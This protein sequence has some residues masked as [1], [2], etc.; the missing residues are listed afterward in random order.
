MEIDV[1]D[2]TQA[3][4]SPAEYET[5]VQ[6]VTGDYRRWKQARARLEDT[7][8]ECWEAYLCDVKALY[9]EPDDNA[10]DRS[11]VARPV[12]YEAVESIHSNILNAMFPASERFFS[13]L[14]KREQDQK[15]AR[16]IEEFLRNKIEAASFF[17]KYALFLKQ[18]VITGN[19]VA[20]VPWCKETRKRRKQVPVTLLGVTVGHR[21]ETVEELIYNGP[22]FEVIDMFDFLIDP[23]APDFE[24]AKVIRRV[25]RSL[26]SLRQISAY[27]N[28]EGLERASLL[29]D[30][31]R[32]RAKRAAFGM[33]ASSGDN[34]TSDEVTLLEAWGDFR[35][36]DRVFENYVCVIANDQRVIRFEQNPY[37]HGKKPFIYSTF[38]PV[39]NEV[40]GIGAIEKS[41]GLQHAINTLTNQKLDVINLSINSPFTYLINDDVFDPN[42][43]VTRPGALIPVKSHDTL[44]P[45][46][47]L[48]NFTVAFNE[49][50]ELKSEIQEATGALKYFT[51]SESGASPARTATEVSALV[52]GG[53]QKFSFF[54]AHLE[55]TSLE[56]FVRMVFENAKQF[57]S[58][59][60][61]LRV[62]GKD[63]NTEFIQLLPELLLDAECVFRIDGSR[64]GLMKE[65]ELSAMIAFIELAGKD[66]EVRAQIDVMA[67]YRKIYR[68]LGFQDEEQIFR[69]SEAGPLEGGVHHAPRL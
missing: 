65:Q 1:S 10:A 31:T 62:P 60:E 43:L 55:N 57:L 51:G 40:Y 49:I 25:K 4:L 69:H 58:E 36:G 59:P 29:E 34:P 46:E 63:G 11:R 20:A 6:S 27:T 21:R 61:T 14:G 48:N 7:W 54:I 23:D 32:K 30:D 64:G 68:R 38:I 12:L 50:A 18:A 19:T 28:L 17:E 52:S 41:L 8:R 16:A 15:N 47:Y 45:V 67:L 37:D 3:A 13:V 42:M 66:P 33:E 44:K 5:L 26:S 56:P 53:T 22:A 2:E 9:T 39:P 35:V 24:Q